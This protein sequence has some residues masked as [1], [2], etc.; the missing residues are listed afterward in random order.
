LP[1]NVLVLLVVSHAVISVAAPSRVAATSARVMFMGNLSGKV[2]WAAD[3]GYSSD[4][5]GQKI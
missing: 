3:T 5:M 2:K 4:A 1:E